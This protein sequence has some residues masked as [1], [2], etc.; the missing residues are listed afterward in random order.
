[1]RTDAL[2]SKANA[3]FPWLMPG[4][5]DTCFAIFKITL[6]IQYARLNNSDC[7][8]LAKKGFQAN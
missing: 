1:M 2:P 5:K 8:E 6:S 4:N 3:A 7:F